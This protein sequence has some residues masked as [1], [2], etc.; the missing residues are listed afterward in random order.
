LILINSGHLDVNIDMRRLSGRKMPV[1][2][3]VSHGGPS[4]YR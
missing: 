2:P 4:I 3:E 1:A